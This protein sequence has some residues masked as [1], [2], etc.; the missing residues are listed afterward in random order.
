MTS[1][2]DRALCGISISVTETLLSTSQS[3]CNCKLACHAA[4]CWH[5]LCQLLAQVVVNPVQLVLREER[6]R[7]PHTAPHCSAGHCQRVFLQWHA[8]SCGGSAVG[9]RLL[10]CVAKPLQ[11]CK[12]AENSSSS[13]SSS[14][15]GGGGSIIIRTVHPRC[16]A[17][18]AQ[19]KDICCQHQGQVLP[20]ATELDSEAPVG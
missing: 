18:A 15:S 3:P 14:G 20:S 2:L 13:S 6:A 1:L 5:H 7:A 10:Q 9:P 8:P 12:T 17:R 4:S 11:T 19:C 16:T